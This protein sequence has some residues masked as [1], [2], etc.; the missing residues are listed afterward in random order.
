MSTSSAAGFFRNYPLGGARPDW[1]NYVHFCG[2]IQR[3]LPQKVRLSRV[4]RHNTAEEGAMSRYLAKRVLALCARDALAR[5]ESL[6]PINPAPPAPPAPI[7]RRPERPLSS[8][9]PMVVLFHKNR[10][11]AGERRT[12]AHRTRRSRAMHIDT[13]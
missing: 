3:H 1:Q 5:T 12:C 13:I 9:L 2:D 6:I 7:R 10:R 8:P 4:A 11:F